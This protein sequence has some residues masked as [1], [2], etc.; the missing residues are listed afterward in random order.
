[1]PRPRVKV[2]ITFLDVQGVKIGEKIVV[3]SL[4]EADT[5]I[6]AVFQLF[7]GAKAACTIERGE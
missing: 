5:S 4:Y 3:E 1:M 7:P 6:G 2:E